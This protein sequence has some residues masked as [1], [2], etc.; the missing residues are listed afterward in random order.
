MRSAWLILL[1]HLSLLLSLKTMRSLFLFLA[2]LLSSAV[3]M[4]VA[5]DTESSPTLAARSWILIDHITGQMLTGS[6]PDRRLEP[7]SLTKLMTAYVLFADLRSG[8]IKED[9]QVP[10]S[11]KA[12]SQSGSAM[13]LEQSKQVTVGQALRG[14]IV[15]SAN[16]GAVAL[17]ELAGGGSEAKFVARMN[18]EATRLGLK[19][20]HFVNASG[21]SVSGHYSS[22]RDIAMLSRALI[23]TFPEYYG[24]YALQSFSFNNIEQ[25]NRNRLLW[26]DSAVDGLKTGQ[27]NTAGFCLAA[28][29]KRGS[30]RLISVVLGAASEESRNQESLKLLNYGF[31]NFATK[32]LYAANEAI[33]TLEVWKGVKNEVK[34]GFLEDFVM[35]LHEDRGDTVE[36]KLDSL[37]PLLAPLKRGQQIGTLTLTVAGR[38][39]GNYPVVVLDDVEEAGFF[40]RLWDLIILWFR[41]L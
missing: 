20:T 10:V 21:A 1:V 17:A 36:A 18:S 29:A 34:V 7:A 4:S 25:P 19:N 13:Y 6:D 14:M 24:I 41:R 31:R 35:S 32:R 37:Q 27:T 39:Y 22:A 23:N 12:L 11:Q 40:G 28:S 16:D 30:R 3:P 5:A 15:L 9:Q 8:A 26:L 38:Y 2:F 33:A